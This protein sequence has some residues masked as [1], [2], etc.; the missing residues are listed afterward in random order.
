VLSL[1]LTLPLVLL[2]LLNV[3]GRRIMRPAAF[4]LAVGF[5]LFQVAVVVT[6]LW[7]A[8][9]PSIGSLEHVLMLVGVQPDGLSRMVLLTVAIIGLCALLTARSVMASADALFSFV[10]LLLI[11]IIGMDATAIA[12][13]LFTLYLFIEVTAI[14]SFVLIGMGRDRGALE[15]A[16]KYLILSA[17]ASF[18]MLSGV[19]LALLIAG[20]TGFQA[21]AAAYGTSQASAFVTVAVCLFVGGALIKSGVV[22]FH[23]WLPDAYSASPSAV[24]TLLAGI[25]TK[26]TGVYVLIRIATSLFGFSFE[27]REALMV[28]GLA[29]IIVGAFAAM[30]QHDMK[31][32]LAYSSISQVGYI[33]LALGCGTPLAL[34]GAAFHFFNHA[35]FKGL[36][37]VNAAAVEQRLG[38]VEFSRMGGLASRMPVT[39]ATSTIAFLSAAGIPPLAGFWSKLI[40][41]LALWNA[42]RYGF[43]AAAV[44]ASV[45]TLGYLLIMQRRAFF[46]RIHAGLEGLRDAGTGI[47]IAEIILAVITVGVGIAYP[48]VLKDLVLPLGSIAVGGV[49][50]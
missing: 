15:G 42:G 34:A 8:A 18:L 39:G 37:F 25:V 5:L 23:G 28:L 41:L 27:L 30:A 11:A 6:P 9:V 4:W 16:F 21:I 22:P 12:G 50:Q 49:A 20:D 38:T 14:T 43:A 10:N 36:L 44:V 32:M 2:A 47:L 35:I 29:S 3:A 24:S 1:L 19:G 13:D 26:A 40:I 17:V 48:F 33:I 46:G 45:V 31:R 7:N